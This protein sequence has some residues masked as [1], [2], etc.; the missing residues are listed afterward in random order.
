MQPA[1]NYPG[2]PGTL[3]RNGS[4]LTGYHVHVTLDHF[5][6]RSG[7]V[8]EVTR[9]GSALRVAPEGGFGRQLIDQGSGYRVLL[10]AEQYAIF[11]RRRAALA[12][13]S[14]LS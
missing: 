7:K 14:V 8:E 9:D 13:K 2:S 1:R 12:T 10:E 4:Q 6:L 3:V 11:R 5:H